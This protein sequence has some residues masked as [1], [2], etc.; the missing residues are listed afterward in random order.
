MTGDQ[1][2]RLQEAMR[3]CISECAGESDASVAAVV[4]RLR[5]EYSE[6]VMP[7]WD[8]FA[9]EGLAKRVRDAMKKT[10]S[11]SLPESLQLPLEFVDGTGKPLPI[12]ALVSLPLDGKPVND[13][14]EEATYRWVP[15]AEAS[16]VDL[17]RHQ[18]LLAT[19]V[20]RSRR[21]LREIDRL[22]KHLAPY[23]KGHEAEPLGPLI[24]RLA[25][26][27]T[28]KALAA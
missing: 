15:T 24:R 7:S 5:V 6:C 13:D 27:E 10:K 19:N 2:V 22:V 12:P 14:D 17:K 25:G 20:K 16:F 26:W 23:V 9:V 1:R 11:S 21:Q 28:P 3:R 8:Q 18:E 4:D